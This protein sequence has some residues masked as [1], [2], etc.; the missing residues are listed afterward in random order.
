MHN[1]ICESYYANVNVKKYNYSQ[2]DLVYITL[3]PVDKFA[4]MNLSGLSS[5]KA[6]G[7]VKE[8]QEVRKLCRCYSWDKGNFMNSCMTKTEGH[9]PRHLVFPL[10]STFMVQYLMVAVLKPFVVKQ[11]LIII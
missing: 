5:L 2:L 8:V 7:R 9:G 4:Y 6:K 1:K 11:G 10:W 3:P